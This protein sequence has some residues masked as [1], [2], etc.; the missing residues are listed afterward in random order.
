MSRRSDRDARYRAYSWGG[1]WSPVPPHW[2][3]ATTARQ[4]SWSRMV[5]VKIPRQ[6]PHPRPWEGQL[7]QQQIKMGTVDWS[8]MFAEPTAGTPPRGAKT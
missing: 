8:G 3:G 1:P 4:R 6:A 5:R 7:W 2:R